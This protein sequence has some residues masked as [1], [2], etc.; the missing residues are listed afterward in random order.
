M[1]TGWEWIYGKPG[2]ETEILEASRLLVG[3]EALRCKPDAVL[4]HRVTIM[5]I[6]RKATFIP[7]EKIP[8]GGWPN[9]K[10]QLWCYSWIDRW[11]D[12]RT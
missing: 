6:E 11:Q 10:A 8:A 12:A 7:R 5:I 4:R 9:I 1:D 2:H 3:G